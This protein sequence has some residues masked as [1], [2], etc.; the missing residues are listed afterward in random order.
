M[1]FNHKS[2]ACVGLVVCGAG[3][4]LASHAAEVEHLCDNE[5]ACIEELYEEK[6]YDPV[7]FAALKLIVG[8]ED[9]LS[10]NDNIFR[11]PTGEKSDIINHFSP[12]LALQ[13]NLDRHAWGLE[14]E[15][16]NGTYFSHSENNYTDFSAITQGRYD[17]SNEAALSARGGYVLDHVGIGSFVDDPGTGN[18]EPTPF[19]TILGEA[20]LNYLPNDVPLH[21]NAAFGAHNIN[22][23]NV[24]MQAGGT[25]IHDDRDRIEYG[26]SMLVGYR[27]HQNNELYLKTAHEE[28]DHDNRIDSSTASTRD[29]S[30]HR[31]LVGFRNEPQQVAGLRYD[32]AVGHL[33]QNYEAARLPDVDAVDL[34]ADAE[35]KMDPMNSLRVRVARDVRDAYSNNYSA[36]LRTRARINYEHDYSEQLRLGTGYSYTNHDFETTSSATISREDHVHGL[37]LWSAYEFY[38]DVEANL[39]YTFTDRNSNDPAADYR[40]N[41]IGIALSYKH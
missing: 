9:S 18:V 22:Y 2:Y 7:D 13:S 3:L 36:Y 15:A 38:E 4:P 24:G 26:G 17:I 30:Q 20:A 19:H 6:K 1:P 37:H 14:I 21:F 33:E 23:E 32:V 16:E 39:Y 12:R 40:A 34:Y 5:L 31:Y 11:S 35:W 25:D 29:S 28:W 27:F 41:V 8:A 10:F